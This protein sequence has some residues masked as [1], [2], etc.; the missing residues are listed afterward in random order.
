MET[1][2]VV[3]GKK[4]FVLYYPDSPEISAPGENRNEFSLQIVQFFERLCTVLFICV[5]C[6]AWDLRSILKTANRKQ[7]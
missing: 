1:G 5:L 4:I 7:A 6:F 3:E 2:D